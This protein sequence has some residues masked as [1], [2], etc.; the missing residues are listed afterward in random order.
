MYYFPMELR[1]IVGAY[2]IIFFA[3]MTFLIRKVG[4]NIGAC[5]IV[6]HKSDKNPLMAFTER[7]ASL[8][9]FLLILSAVFYVFDFTPFF[10]FHEFSLPY[11]YEIRIAGVFLAGIALVLISTALLQ[12]RDSWRMGIEDRSDM[13]TELVS[14]GLFRFFRH[15]VYQFAIVLG[16]SI[17]FTDPH[18]VSLL[19]V[20]VYY[21][22]LSVQARMEEE[23]LLRKWGERYRDFMSSRSTWF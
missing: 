3:V 2:L 12:M 5:P 18:P 23:F 10:L 1:I 11:K 14:R 4:S 21:V 8:S 19:S 20:T 16:V 22:V 7:A 6:R 17:F 9:F 13:E 15:P